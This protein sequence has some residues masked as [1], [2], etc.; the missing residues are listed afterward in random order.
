MAGMA[1]DCGSSCASSAAGSFHQRAS[2][3]PANPEIHQR[4]VFLKSH[5]GIEPVPVP[6]SMSM[7]TAVELLAILRTHATTVTCGRT[8]R[9]RQ[10]MLVHISKASVDVEWAPSPSV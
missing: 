7:L 5:G 2:I 1:T 10:H 6:S 8:A 3:W 9:L 4:T